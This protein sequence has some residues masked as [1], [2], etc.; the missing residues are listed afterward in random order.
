[1][2][3]RALV[4]LCFEIDDRLVMPPL[5]VQTRA[6]IAGGRQRVPVDLNP[7]YGGTI[8]ASGVYQML[9]ALARGCSEW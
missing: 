6:L 2:T 3:E 7:N 1:V 8:Q 5:V 9:S 4:C